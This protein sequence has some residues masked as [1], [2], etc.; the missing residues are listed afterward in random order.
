MAW[1]PRLTQLNDALGELVPHQEGITKFVKAA[2][3]KPQMINF[4]GS[5]MDIWSNVLDEA[6]KTNRVN[7]LV[8]SV[9]V[10]YPDNP[11]LKS[12]ITPIEINYS[13]SPDIDKISNWNAVEEDTL[14]VLTMDISSLLP[15]SFLE[16][17]IAASRSV[18]KVEIRNGSMVDVGTGFLFKLQEENDL[19]FI[20]NFHVINDKEHIEHTRIIFNYEEDANGESKASKSF[21]IDGN[22]PW[23][24]SPLK[25]LDTTIFQ[26]IPIGETLNEFGFLTLKKTDVKKNDFVNIIQHPAGQMKQISLYHNIVTSADL[27]EVQY[28]TDTLKGSSGSPVFNSNWDIVAL[29]HSGGNK[30]KEDDI[31]ISKYRNVGININGIIDFMKSKS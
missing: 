5:A 14:E 3:I 4:T 22:G 26:L 28:L 10:K 19:F 6:E 23:Y 7:D 20:T 18:A 30:K 16:R 21:K 8:K 11:Y 2:G 31:T 24:T 25:E 13:L 12:A 17:G 29:H 1:S 27:R 9:M 15:I